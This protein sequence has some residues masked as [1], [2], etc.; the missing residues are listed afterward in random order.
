LQNQSTAHQRWLQ[1]IPQPR[2]AYLQPAGASPAAGMLAAALVQGLPML[3]HIYC[4]CCSSCFCFWPYLD[5]ACVPLCDR[6]A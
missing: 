1:L 2:K 6:T 4:C 3:L 5:L